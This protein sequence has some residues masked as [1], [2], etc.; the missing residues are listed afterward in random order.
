MEYSRYREANGLAVG[1]K[2]SHL[3]WNREIHCLVHK[4]LPLV[5]VINHINTVNFLFRP[6]LFTVH[7]NMILHSMPRSRK[8]SLLFVFFSLN[9][10]Y[11]YISPMRATC[12]THLIS[13]FCLPNNIS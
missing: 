6:Y 7:F 1:Q 8:M 9:R 13:I 2:I 5:S 3:L 10:I 4:S 11:I 12:L